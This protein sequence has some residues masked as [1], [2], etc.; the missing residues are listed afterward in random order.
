[1]G[2]KLTHLTIKI[3]ILLLL[4]GKLPKNHVKIHLSKASRKNALF[5][6]D[7]PLI[8]LRYLKW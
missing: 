5:L 4:K 7:T 8:N 6:I 1:M 3:K 2:Q